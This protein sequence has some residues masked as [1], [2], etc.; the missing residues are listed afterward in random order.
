MACGKLEDSG[1]GARGGSLLPPCASQELNRGLSTWLCLHLLSQLPAWAGTAILKSD[2]YNGK[3]MD[4]N[5]T[6]RI[7]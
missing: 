1:R 2:N 7:I 4:V 6:V 5:A 3:K